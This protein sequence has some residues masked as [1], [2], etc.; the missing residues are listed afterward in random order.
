MVA[1]DVSQ[2]AVVNVQL[3][4]DSF[5]VTH[6]DMVV[7]YVNVEA[8]RDTVLFERHKVKV[9]LRIVAAK[10]PTAQVDCV[11][12]VEVVDEHEVLFFVY[13]EPT[14]LVVV[15]VV[16]NCFDA[17]VERAYIVV[18]EAVGDFWTVHSYLILV[19]ANVFN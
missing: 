14:G 4:V 3:L 5:E 12:I 13:F 6:L 1:F 9:E 7:E 19:V 17:L 10:E 8:K 16:G 11:H 2:L 15:V 18:A